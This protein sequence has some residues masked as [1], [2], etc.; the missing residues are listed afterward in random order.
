MNNDKTLMT[1]MVSSFLHQIHLAK[2]KL[3]SK[4]IRSFIVGENLNSTIGTAFIEGYKLNV[5]DADFEQARTILSLS[6]T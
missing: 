6:K 3:E 2:A 4:G 5:S 1:V